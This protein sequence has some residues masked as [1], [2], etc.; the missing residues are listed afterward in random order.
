MTGLLLKD[1]YNLAKIGKQY[2]LIFAAMSVWAY[3]TKNPSF[4]SMY[5]VLC[6]SM[7][8][9]TSFSYDEYVHFNKYALTMPIERKTLVLEKY[10]LLL[11]AV[12]GGTAVGILL[13]GLLNLMV[14]ENFV[15]LTV[16]SIVIG[17]VFWV[18]YSISIP[19]VYKVGVEKARMVM[20]GVY[21][22]VFAVIYVCAKVFGEMEA[23]KNLTYITWL[24]PAGAVIAAAIATMLS[25]GVSVSIV[26]K[27]DI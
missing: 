10:I 21:L 1:F 20:V 15:E 12:A 5:V 3:F 24:I 17:C 25:Y 11:L 19:I 8:V 9:L 6:S 2:L 22:G 26:Q 27:K 4:I 16:V 7:L 14:K 18:S 23:L 13:G